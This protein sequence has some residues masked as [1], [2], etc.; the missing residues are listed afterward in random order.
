MGKKHYLVYH[1]KESSYGEHG[2]HLLIKTLKTCRRNNYHK[3][4]SLPR[5]SKQISFNTHMVEKQTS[6]MPGCFLEQAFSS[7][8][9]SDR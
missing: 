8:S 3:A 9:L 2:A 7:L 4:L 6:I 5:S 1:G